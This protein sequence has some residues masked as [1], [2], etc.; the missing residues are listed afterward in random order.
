MVPAIKK[1]FHIAHWALPCISGPITSMGILAAGSSADSR[2]ANSSA[3]VMGAA[4]HPP[5]PMAAK[6][7]SSWRHITP[8]GI[9]VVPPV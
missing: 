6:K 2:P 5:P 9:P 8:L 4:P 1:A 7:M 3:E